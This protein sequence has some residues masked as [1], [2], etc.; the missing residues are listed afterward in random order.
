MKNSFH[1]RARLV[2]FLANIKQLYT[3]T[4]PNGYVRNA[5]KS[6]CFLLKC[7]ISCQFSFETYPN[8]PKRKVIRV[9]SLSP[10]YRWPG[11]TQSPCGLGHLCCV[12][13]MIGPR[14]RAYLRPTKQRVTVTMCSF[15]TLFC[16]KRTKK[17][18]RA[19]P[20]FPEL[21]W[22]QKR[23]TSALW[24]LTLRFGSRQRWH[25]SPCGGQCEAKSCQA[26]KWLP[27]MLGSHF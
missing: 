11:T 15:L 14:N 18:G 21:P 25:W 1:P 3:I 10:A 5:L 17:N 7:M 27:C 26:H 16:S 9:S 24:I 22:C 6:S 12:G 20:R 8:H 2:R 4:R 13:A 19:I 23:T